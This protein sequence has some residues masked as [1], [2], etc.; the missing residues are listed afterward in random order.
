MA[1]SPLQSTPS[2]SSISDDCDND[3]NDESL[4]WDDI[5]IR[6][7]LGKGSFSK[8]KEV[9][10][11][12]KHHQQ[13]FG[14]RKYAI[15]YLRNCTVQKERVFQDAAV[16]LAIEGQFL[17]YLK[18]ENIIELHA[19]G[20]LEEAYED[21]CRHFLVLDRLDNILDPLIHDWRCNETMPFINLVTPSI[22]ERIQP[23]AIPV[24]KAM[25]YLHSNGIVFRDLK[26]YNIGFQNGI[27]KLFDFGLARFVKEG[28]RL[29]GR[30][31]SALY[32][33]P[34]VVLSLDYGLP[35]DVYSFAI[36]L[37]ELLML[38]IPFEGMSRTELERAVVN[39]NARPVIEKSVGTLKLQKMI[40]CAWDASPASRPTFTR[41]REV[42]EEEVTH[43]RQI[44]IA[45]V[46]RARAA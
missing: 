3:S 43:E 46:A 8:V 20:C 30:V 27:V 35:A 45:K 17:T 33:A 36:M 5:R 39:E 18:H 37:W 31:G 14:K 25:E 40:T 28:R 32:M 2:S 24:A 4:S 19:Q 41:I 44:T 12:D 15:K 21:D 26:P 10:F 6:G 29:T 23:I 38:E 13:R 11:R 1:I 16:D 22:N 34:E 42:L 7:I 9:T